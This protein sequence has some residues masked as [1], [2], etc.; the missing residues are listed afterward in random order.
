M[1]E[2]LQGFFVFLSFRSK[3]FKAENWKPTAAEIKQQKADQER[4]IK[5]ILSHY[6]DLIL[7][8]IPYRKAISDTN[9]AM[10]EMGYPWANYNYIHDTL[11][12]AGKFKRVTLQHKK[13]SFY[14]D[15]KG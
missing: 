3:I 7:K 9:K 14:P 15:K 8:G 6:D 12:R 5:D 13:K 2:S 11:R 1:L 10:K 4:F